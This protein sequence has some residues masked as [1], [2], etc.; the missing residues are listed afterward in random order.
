VSVLSG[1]HMLLVQHAWSLVP[2]ALLAVARLVAGGNLAR[3]PSAL[4]LLLALY[5]GWKII[6]PQIN[7]PGQPRY[8]MGTELHAGPQRLL[9]L[10]LVAALMLVSAL[11]PGARWRLID[12]AVILLVAITALS[13]WSVSGR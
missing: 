2:L 12:G 1:L 6:G 3:I 10:G 7:P 8:V 13:V 5:L 11:L 9:A 4:A